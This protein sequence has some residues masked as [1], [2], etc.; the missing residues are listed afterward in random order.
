[1]LNQGRETGPGPSGFLA[2]E[3]PQLLRVIHASLIRS[4]TELCFYM[5]GFESEIEQLS[6]SHSPRRVMDEILPW[7]HHWKRAV[8]WIQ[9]V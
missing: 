6:D 2:Y 1:M 5:Q 4:S 9:R 8:V 7:L 3:L